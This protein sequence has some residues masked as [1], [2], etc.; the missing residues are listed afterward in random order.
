M[1]SPI[2]ASPVGMSALETMR[3]Y[4]LQPCPCAGAV[5]ELPEVPAVA[6][7]VDARVVIP[8]DGSSGA[9]RRLEQLSCERSVKDL[10]PGRLV[11]SRSY[12]VTFVVRV[13]WDTLVR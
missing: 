4:R 3:A 10:D 11:V 5:V 12:S 13:D 6:V 9:S 2:S 8:H 7:V 1:T